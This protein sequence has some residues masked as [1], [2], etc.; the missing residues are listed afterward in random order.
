MVR[1]SEGCR[2]LNERFWDK[3]RNKVKHGSGLKIAHE[4]GSRPNTVTRWF[5]GT[6]APSAGKRLVLQRRYRIGWETW[7]QP[8]KQQAAERAA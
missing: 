2:L 4:T 3:K 8:A 5:Q 1:N 7:D 6:G